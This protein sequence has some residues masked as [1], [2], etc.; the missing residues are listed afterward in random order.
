V[1]EVGQ[2]RWEEINLVT[3]GGNYG[4]KFYEGLEEASSIYPTQ[5]NLV[6]P[7]AGFVHAEPIYVYRHAGQGA[8]PN[9]AGDSVTG[10]IVYHGDRFPEFDGAYFFADFEFQ[11]VWVLRRDGGDVTVERIAADLGIAAFGRDP[12]NGDVL[13][14]NYFQNSVKRLVRVDDPG[15]PFPQTLSDT[16]AFADLATLSPNPGIVSYEPKIAFWSDHAI[17]RRW[18]TIPNL[19]DTV[20]FAEDTNWTLPSGMVWIKHFDL[21]LDRGNPASP[22]RR[23]ETR[24]I[25]KNDAGNYGV[26]YRWNDEQT[27]AFL[28]PDGGE[29]FFV[30]ITNQGIVTNQLWEIPSRAGCFACHTVAGGHALTFNTREMNHTADMNGNVGNQIDALAAAGYFSGPVPSGD[31]LPV[32]AQAGDTNASIEFRARSYLAVNCVQCHQAGGIGGG[33]WDARP[34]LTL[35]ETKMIDGPLD[36]NGGDPLNRV[37]VPGDT[38][39]SVLLRRIKADG[40]GRMPP[41]ATHELDE[42][43]IALLTEWIANEL[44][45]RQDFA[46]WQIANFGSTNNPMAAAGADPDADGANNRY[47]FLT[48]TPPQTNSEPWKITIDEELGTV[49]VSFLRLADRGFLV[50]TAPAFG[51][52][53]LWDVPGNQLYFGATDTFTT[54]TGPL[55]PDETN[56][57]FRVRILEP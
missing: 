34:Y 35:A 16:G 7:P 33:I 3:N 6:P 48:R 45:N 36:L 15:A 24:L 22:K 51:D 49:G 4:W 2:D 13:F 57:Y 19:T 25:V 41:L 17:K 32:H 42:Q 8:D 21:E 14:A 29:Q 44:P 52:W 26:S 11:N 37:I 23:L 40:F 5:P 55:S 56:R 47:E 50:E 10:G 30:T 38:N 12:S 27:E 54:L 53:T 28:V 39:H 43:A 20:T 9:F 31:T 18:F 46:Q 1:G